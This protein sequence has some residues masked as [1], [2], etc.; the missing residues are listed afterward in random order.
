MNLQLL[1]L[2]CAVC[3]AVSLDRFGTRVG[4]VNRDVEAENA[5]EVGAAEAVAVGTVVI[6]DTV[7]ALGS[8]STA[9][10]FFRSLTKKSVQN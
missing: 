7:D 8:L 9:L 1:V 3:T 10:D 6:A 5:V 2:V 4:L